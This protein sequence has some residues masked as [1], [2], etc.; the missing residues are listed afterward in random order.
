[1]EPN[2][3]HRR[4]N[5]TF[6]LSPWQAKTENSGRAANVELRDLSRPP[7]ATMLTGYVYGVTHRLNDPDWRDKPRQEALDK[8]N[9]A[10][11]QVGNSPEMLDTRAVIYLSMDKYAEAIKDLETAIAAAPGA[12][13]YFHLAQAYAANGDDAE[14]LA[15]V[16][17]SLEAH[18][19]QAKAATD[20][21]QELPPTPAWVQQARDLE[22]KLSPKAAAAAD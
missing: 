22:A 15:A 8:I 3:V 21:G 10:L 7:K 1:M 4:Y 12:T 18:E 17:R 6:R 13:R 5:Y 16:G 19:A 11:A 20:R 9:Q 2:F 14:A